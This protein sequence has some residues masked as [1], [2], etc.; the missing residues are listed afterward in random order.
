MKVST[1]I[2]RALCAALVIMA[3]LGTVAGAAAQGAS[4]QSTSEL[5]RLRLSCD[6]FTRNRDNTWSPIRSIVVG[7]MAVSP[8]SSFRAGDSVG[9]AD[10]GAILDQE[11]KDQLGQAGAL[12]PSGPPSR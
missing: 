9:G 5:S 3:G 4:P 1:G 12:N 10:L 2:S 8:T 7:V 11:C 6:D